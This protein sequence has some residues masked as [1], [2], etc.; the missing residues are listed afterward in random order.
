MKCAHLVIGPAGSG[1]STFCETVKQHCD[2]SHRSLHI[3]NLDPAAED[4]CLG[5]PV[6][7]DIREL[8]S[9]QDAMEELSLGPN[10]GLIFCMEYIEQN[11][12]WL[13]DALEPYGED[14]YLLFDCPGQIE[15]YSHLTVF[16]TFV[17]TL[18]NDGWTVGC[19]YCLDGQFTE[20][21][22]KYIA[23]CLNALGSMVMLE[24]PHVSVLTKVDLMR[25]KGRGHGRG[26]GEGEDQGSRYLPGRLASQ[27]PWGATEEIEDEEGALIIP[28]K[29]NLLR[30]LD[31][32]YGHS[33]KFSRLN[34][35][36][37]SVLE[38]Y[39]M[40]GFVPLDITDEGSVERLM[41]H[42]DMAVGWMGADELEVRGG[43]DAEEDGLEEA[44]FEGLVV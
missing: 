7:I 36:I 38:E 23:G 1:K 9:L 33:E 27:Q 18:K 31:D 6:S 16:Q 41:M 25:K 10:G 11:M 20:E 26:R 44:D 35:L 13:V 28:D 29:D 2:A 5:Y 19:V 37:A 24:L 4:E 12:E 34:G 40:V 17:Q 15:L 30:E 14:D 21:P 8:I 42:M 39:A 3:A 43:Y 32:S 22:S